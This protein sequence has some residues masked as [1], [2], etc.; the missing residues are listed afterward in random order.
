MTDPQRPPDEQ[1]TPPKPRPV[2]AS[3]KQ[4]A[5]Y[6]VVAAAVLFFHRR[7]A[8]PGATFNT[9]DLR[10]YFIPLRV[11]VQHTLRAGEWPF[12]QRSIYLGFP[13]WSFSEAALFQPT[14]WLYLGVEAARGVTLGALTHLVVAALG[15]FGWMRHRGRS[16][17]AAASGAFIVALG[18]YT[19]VHLE[20]WTF[21]ATLMWLPWALLA[22]D[23]ALRRGLS[24]ASLL[25][26]AA[27]IA[28]LWFGGAAQLAYFG[29]L[30][31]GGYVVFRVL[32]TRGRAW[33]VLLVLPAGMLLAA[34]LLLAGAE[35]NANGPR[36]AGITLEFASLY[37]WMDWHSFVLL[38]LPDAWGPR[39]AYSGPW[40]YWEMTGYVGLAAL[41][42]VLT[43][44][45]RGIGWYFLFLFGFSFVVALGTQT[46]VFELLFNHLP[47]FNKFRVA[48]RTFFIAN[49]AA[50]FLTAEAVDAL[51]ERPRWRSALPPLLGALL[52]AGAVGFIG[53]N[54]ESWGFRAEEVR[55]QLPLALG[56]LLVLATW[57]ALKGVVPRAVFPV[58]IALLLFVDLHQRFAD[59][60]PVTEARALRQAA[61]P[62][63][64]PTLPRG[65]RLAQLGM[66]ANLL[67]SWGVEGANGY[68]QLLVAR[69]FDLH[70]LLREGRFSNTHHL[71]PRDH[72]YGRQTL[73]PL[74]P[75]FPLF[76]TPHLYT[77]GPMNTPPQ[78]RLVGREGAYWHYEVPALP[79]TFFTARHE[80]MD[81]ARFG[82]QGFNFKPFETVA[83][84]PTQEPLPPT[85]D[86]HPPRAVPLTERTANHTRV[87]VDA[88]VPGLLVVMDPWYPGWRAEVDGQRAPLL[89]ADYAFMA[90]PVPA[91]RH[92]VV[93]RYRPATL[94]PGL[95]C[96][97]A[98]LGGAGGW[99]LLRRRRK[100]PAVG[101]D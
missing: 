93:L 68:S 42:L 30:V 7:A 50:G 36:A 69:I 38:L 56:L 6:L 10:D 51:A 89:R 67:A 48:S 35:L 75:L 25:A 70:Y 19:T 40:N 29:T 64:P 16:L 17:G 96:V 52:L 88:P 2:L 54:A 100:A 12:W 101:V 76:A 41:V 34:P 45:P 32:G 4:L 98:V 21:G 66:N 99:S 95:A 24:P 72:E 39:D 3:L 47:G 37:N 26:A 74:S 8:A 85:N 33:P 53:R 44:R 49:F 9:E 46:P 23:V 43:V 73:A 60:M 81:D 84:A 78:M 55:A 1:H 97:L 65:A 22:V 91:G 15:V 94:F 5:P 82:A 63:P 79:L 86:S 90:V 71:T 11:L 57:V 83:L 27:C 58:G 31:V 20:H 87:T 77:R 28:G 92:E 80:V 13:L 14:T 59:T 62:G 18:G 61:L